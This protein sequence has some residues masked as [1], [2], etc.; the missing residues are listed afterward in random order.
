MV[1][2][3]G[4]TQKMMGVMDN[5]FANGGETGT[6]SGSPAS[7]SGRSKSNNRR[8][9]EEVMEAVDEGLD[10]EEEMVRV[11]QEEWS[12]K[13]LRTDVP[14]MQQHVLLQAL[15][16]RKYV[17]L[18]EA[19]EICE[20]V[21]GDRESLYRLVGELNKELQAM[22][23]RIKSSTVPKN[24]NE[25]GVQTYLSLINLVKDESATQSTRMSYTEVSYFKQVIEAIVSQEAVNASSIVLMN[26]ANPPPVPRQSQDQASTSAAPAP[27]VSQFLTKKEKEKVL[28]RL[29][30]EG[31]LRQLKHDGREKLTLGPRTYLELKSLLLEMDLPQGV[32]D[33]LA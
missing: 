3:G 15:L 25:R 19:Q 21:T 7:A 16:E 23:L 17:T 1:G 26:L 28:K 10:L 14:R 27:V 12:E 32:R 22:Q 33:A 24:G 11:T 6:S 2:R 31:W 18:S 29:R 5:I 9:S 4:L 13:G 8:A 20:A 30:R